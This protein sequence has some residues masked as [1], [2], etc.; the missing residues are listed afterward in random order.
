MR[1]T[2]EHVDALMQA[3][4]DLSKRARQARL[5]YEATPIEAV[6]GRV[7]RFQDMTRLERERTEAWIAAEGALFTLQ[8]QDRNAELDARL[9]ANRPDLPPLTQDWLDHGEDGDL[10]TYDV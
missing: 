10:S 9:V 4:R 1:E 8:T 7:L 3:W 5:A 6:W 2:Q